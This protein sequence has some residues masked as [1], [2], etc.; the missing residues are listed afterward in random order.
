MVVLISNDF[1]LSDLRYSFSYILCSHHI[2]S[3][4]IY[5]SY[6]FKKTILCYK[7]IKII[8]QLCM[9]EFSYKENICMVATV[10]I[11]LKFIIKLSLNVKIKCIH[12][13]YI[14]I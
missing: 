14:I 6:K 2:V 9:N 12:R 4:R 1:C 11:W 10:Y 5:M 7:I 13:F 3:L 8:Q